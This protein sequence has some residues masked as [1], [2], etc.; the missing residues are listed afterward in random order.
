MAIENVL[1]AERLHLIIQATLVSEQLLQM[2]PYIY[3]EQV[4][5]K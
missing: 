2:P 3:P 1:L 5:N 4:R